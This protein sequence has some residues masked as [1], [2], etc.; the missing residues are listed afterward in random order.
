MKILTTRNVRWPWAGGALVAALVIGGIAGCKPPAASSAGTHPYSVAEAE[1]AVE[2]RF[3]VSRYF[4]NEFIP[5]PGAPA[6]APLNPRRPLR[7]GLNWIAND[8]V[9]PWLLGREKGFFSDVGIDLQ[10][11]EGGPGRDHLNTLFAGHVDV[12]TG[13]AE[14]LF[15]MIT[16]P[17]GS[18]LMMI[19]AN[20]K[21]SPLCW[22][23]LDKSVPPDQRSSRKIGPADLRGRTIGVQPGGPYYLGYVLGQIGM[24]LD[25]VKVVNAGAGPDALIA[26]AMDYYQGWLDNQP[27]LLEKNGYHNWAALDFASV[28]YPDYGDISTV[29]PA[30]YASEKELLRRY[31]YALDRSMRYLLE[32]P[33]ESAEIVARTP[34]VS[35]Y[36]LGAADV[37]WRIKRDTPLFQGDGTQPLLGLDAGELHDTAVQMYRYHSLELPAAPK[38]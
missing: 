15:Q 29:T 23:T 9:A 11:V 31:V 3:D 38:P 5:V 13:F 21:T 33:E 1:A 30:F 27:R 35:S 2:S 19:C 7:L 4:T 36:Q 20:M 28:G 25:D 24:S 26:G 22:L 37:L 10:I 8:Q 14:P 16:S 17:T 6:P 18:A 12:Y 32:H 34:E